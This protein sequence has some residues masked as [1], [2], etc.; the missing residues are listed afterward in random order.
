VFSEASN[1]VAIGRPVQAVA[2]QTPGCGV[3][4][5]RWGAADM[6]GFILTSPSDPDP[7]ALYCVGKVVDLG[8]NELELDQLSRLGRCADA[9]RVTGSV[10]A[11]Y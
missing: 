3:V 7:E 10:A 9:E 5:A 8:D 2:E 1:P 6:G 4:Y 11:C